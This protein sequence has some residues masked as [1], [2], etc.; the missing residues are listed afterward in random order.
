MH[1]FNKK[2]KSHKDVVNESI[3][4]LYK[5][6]KIKDSVAGYEWF[7]TNYS[8]S[9]YSK[10]ALERIHEIMFSKAQKVDTI[11]AYN[12]FVFS[13]PTAKQVKLANELANEKERKMYTNLGFMGFWDTDYK[14]EKKAR[15]LLIKA[16]QIERFPTD[17]KLYGKRK[18]GYLIVA[19]RMYQ[20]LQEEFDDTDATLRHLESQ[21]FKDFVKTFKSIMSDIRSTLNRIEENSRNISRYTEEMVDVSKNGFS[22]AKADRAMSAYYA[23]KHRNWEKFMHYRDKGYN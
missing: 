2:Y 19:N 9:K 15:E 10:Q 1:E 20:L 16:K 18:S 12:S 13:Y 7:I 6:I 5:L 14:K 3:D 22:D 21:E 4:H 8:S 23:Q 11:A 17:N